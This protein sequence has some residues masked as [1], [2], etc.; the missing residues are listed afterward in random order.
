MGVLCVGYRARRAIVGGTS[1]RA[2]DAPVSRLLQA[3][4][5][6]EHTFCIRFD[7]FSCSVRC[8]IV[9]CQVEPKLVCWRELGW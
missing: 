9:D 1:L 4:H 5:C 3:G 8:K 2:L 6:V 7:G